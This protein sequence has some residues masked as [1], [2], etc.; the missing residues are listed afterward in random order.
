[1]NTRDKLISL[2]TQWDSKQASRKHHNPHALGIYFQQ[3][4]RVILDI[5][6]G[7]D[8][9]AALVAGFS[10]R[11]LDFILRGFGFQISSVAEQ[12]GSGIYRPVSSN[13]PDA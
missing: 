3:A 4:D 11:M 7:A 1:M 10:G 2:L 13:H 6:L 9:R 5:D 12:R 8:T